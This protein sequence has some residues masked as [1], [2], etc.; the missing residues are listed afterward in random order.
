M[1]LKLS[2]HKITRVEFFFFN[3]KFEVST[4]ILCSMITD[5]FIFMW[6]LNVI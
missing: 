5:G 6:I 3:T 1:N 2:Y 4:P